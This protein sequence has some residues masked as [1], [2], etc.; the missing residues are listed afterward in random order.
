VGVFE[1]KMW[2]YL[3]YVRN[4]GKYTSETVEAP[5]E[6]T[7]DVEDAMEIRLKR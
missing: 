3:D 4:S 1:E 2:E 5:L 7:K 6:F